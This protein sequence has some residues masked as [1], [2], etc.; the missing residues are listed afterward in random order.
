VKVSRTNR[1]KFNV[2]VRKTHDSKIGKEKEEEKER[3]GGG[4]VF[5]FF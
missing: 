1:K 4:G 5:S 3:G 2:N